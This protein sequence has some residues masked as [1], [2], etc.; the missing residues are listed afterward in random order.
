VLAGA[1]GVIS[2]LV[3]DAVATVTDVSSGFIGDVLLRFVDDHADHDSGV[4]VDLVVRTP[5]IPLPRVPL[6]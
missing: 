1:S 3:C 6:A 2:C 4:R 5:E